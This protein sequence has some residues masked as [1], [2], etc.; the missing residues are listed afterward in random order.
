MRCHVSHEKC[1]HGERCVRDQGGVVLSSSE[2]HFCFQSWLLTSFSADL[3]QITSNKSEESA[4]TWPLSASRRYA[5]RSFGAPKEGLVTPWPWRLDVEPAALSLAAT[6][7]GPEPRPI[8][9][10]RSVRRVRTRLGAKGAKSSRRGWD[11]DVECLRKAPELSGALHGLPKVW[12]CLSLSSWQV[13]ALDGGLG[14]QRGLE[15][16]ATRS[17]S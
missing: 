7:E 14:D 13:E 10:P 12:S 2:C 4:S 9:K 5:V 11:G 16:S 15:G 1:V 3:R 6:P 17:Q 8:L